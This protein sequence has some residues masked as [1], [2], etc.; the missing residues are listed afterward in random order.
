[1]VFVERVIPLGITSNNIII[2]QRK[3]EFSDLKKELDAEVKYVA[4]ELKLESN[5][6]YAMRKFEHTS[7]SR[8][9]VK[10]FRRDDNIP[11]LQKLD[12]SGTINFDAKLMHVRKIRNTKIQNQALGQ[13]KIFLYAVARIDQNE[14]FKLIFE[15]M[16]CK[17]EVLAVF[18]LLEPKENKIHECYAGDFLCEFRGNLL[19]FRE[20]LIQQSITYPA[21]VEGQFNQRILQARARAFAEHKGVKSIMHTMVTTHDE[22][23]EPIDVIGRYHLLQV[24]GEGSVSISC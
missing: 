22:P 24:L 13:I 3:H 10:F 21:H 11:V 5:V 18:D 23:I 15:Q 7:W 9:T 2:C 12:E 6:I 8:A 4:D 19:S 1:M 16:L 17:N 14:E 20:I